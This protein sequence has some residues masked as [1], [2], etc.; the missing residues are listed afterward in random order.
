MKNNDIEQM[1]MNNASLDELIKIKIEQEFMSDLKKSKNVPIKKVY[2]L[3]KDVPSG[4]IFSKE[5]VFRHFNRNSKCETLIN[6]VQAEALI[7]LQNNVREKMLKGELSAF[8]T[9]NAYVKFEKVEI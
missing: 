3:I 4:K 6:G 7:G 1:L 8:T 2:T 5:A 9:D